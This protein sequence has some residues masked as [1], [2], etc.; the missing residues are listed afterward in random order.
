M[1]LGNFFRL[2]YVQY[3]FSFH[4]QLSNAAWSLQTFKILKSVSDLKNSW[5]ELNT[6]Y[7]PVFNTVK[8][9]IFVNWQISYFFV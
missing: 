2:F 6:V 8:G 4:V 1:L 5:D 9:K 7:K 3:S